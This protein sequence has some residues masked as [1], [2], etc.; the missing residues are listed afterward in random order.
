MERNGLFTPV[1]ITLR[2]ADRNARRLPPSSRRTRTASTPTATACATTRKSRRAGLPRDSPELAAAYDFLVQQGLATYYRLKSNPADADSDD[3]G[4]DDLL[5]RQFGTDPLIPD[6]T[7]L[8]IDGLNLPPL[9]RF[10]QPDR[11]D[12][13]PAIGQRYELEKTFR[14]AP[15]RRRSSS[16]FYTDIPVAYD[17]DDR[18]AWSDLRGRTRRSRRARPDGSGWGICVGGHSATA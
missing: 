6:G 14:R 2:V 3:D 15:T 12:E 10:F 11:Y 13:R 7:D 1:R 9:A 17:G 4:L 5:E 18:T 16:V 8:G